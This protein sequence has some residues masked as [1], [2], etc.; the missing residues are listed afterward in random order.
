M[1]LKFHKIILICAY[2]YLIFQYFTTSFMDSH[3][4]IDIVYIYR[5]PGNLKKISKQLRMF[6]NNYTQINFNYTRPMRFSTDLKFIL[7][8]T[9]AFSHYS[10]S[11]FKN[12]QQAFIEQNCSYYNCYL[13][14][15]KSL[16][17]DPTQFDAILFDVENNWDSFP[18]IRISFQKY[19][20]T[21]SESASN[22]PICPPHFDDFY[23]YTWSYRL[24][25]DIRWSYITIL[26]TKGNFVGPKVNMTWIN[27]MLPTSNSVKEKLKTK[28][29]TAAWFVS[30]CQSQSKRENV[31]NHL[32]I[33]LKKYDLKVD[34]YGWCGKLT[35]PRDRLDDCLELLQDHYY[36][37]LAFENSLSEDYVT[38]KI[39]YPMQHYTV[40]IVYGGA[41]YSRF[42]PPGSYINAREHDVETIAKIMVKAIQE[43]KVY[44]EYF[45]WHNHYVYKETPEVADVCTLCELLN[46]PKRNQSVVK[47]F[48]KWWNP[49]YEKLCGDDLKHMQQL[50]KFTL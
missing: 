24:D 15:D 20:F 38:E 40:P 2:T 17:S 22:Y 18:L 28:K 47:N 13:T 42:L 31:T 25:S 10:S 46:D 9:E 21:A 14:N 44:E 16:I 49:N 43:P 12:G 37:Y 11:V 3:E 36:F 4:E 39:L 7:K 19:I 48:R 33:A 23:N 27:P 8:W 30:N 45:R 32:N 5:I 50:N 26:D 35:C 1:T 41:N 29:K 6:R 34:I